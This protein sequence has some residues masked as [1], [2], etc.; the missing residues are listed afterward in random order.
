M[1][2]RNNHLSKSRPSVAVVVPNLNQGKFLEQALIS[3]ISQEGAEIF[4]AVMDAGS[5]DNSKDVIQKYEKHLYYWRSHS[6]DGQA[7]AINE[8]INRLPE[9]DYIC[10]LN[11]DDVFYEDGLTKM[12]DY[13]ETNREHIAVYAKAYITDEFGEIKDTYPTKPFSVSDLAKGCFICQPATLIR[14]EAWIKTG[15]VDPSYHMCMDYDLW[16]RI[17]RVGNIGYLEEFTACSRDHV[18]TKTRNNKNLHYEESFALLKKYIGYIPWHWAK[19][20]VVENRKQRLR[21]SFFN[22]LLDNIVG[23]FIFTKNWF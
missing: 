11:A 5:V 1:V 15:G 13:L 12:I 23:V 17:I 7:D 14:R 21:I 2:Q 16:W 6:D 4:I 20:Y 9:T 22:K 8:G 19:S 3:I 10:W 18:Y